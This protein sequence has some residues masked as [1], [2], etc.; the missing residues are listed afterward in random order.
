MT[1]QYRSPQ[2]WK[3]KGM[4]MS[5]HMH[6]VEPAH[7]AK[8]QGTDLISNSWEEETE[9]EGGVCFVSG[10]GRNSRGGG[11]FI[12]NLLEVSQDQLY[13]GKKD[14]KLCDHSPQISVF[15][16]FEIWPLRFYTGPFVLMSE[17]WGE[18]QGEKCNKDRNGNIITIYGV[19]SQIC[20]ENV[21][22]W[23]F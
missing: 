10:H 3:C 13:W 22:N 14:V 11:S 21:F 20:N 2:G 19:R 9:E 18:R 8:T 1:F 12:I 6:V 5:N 17:A 23:T 4:H 15:S 16:S 7:W